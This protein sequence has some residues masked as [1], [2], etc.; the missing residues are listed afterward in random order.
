MKLNPALPLLF[1]VLTAP[2]CA[3]GQ[4]KGTDPKIDTLKAEHLSGLKFRSIGPAFMSGRI[5]DVAV[6]PHK[7]NTWYVGVGS[8]GV[9]KTEN[10]G[11][12]WAMPF[13]N[14]GAAA[15]VVAAGDELAAGWARAVRAEK[16]AAMAAGAP[17]L[18]RTKR[19]LITRWLK[20]RRRRP[21]GEAG[22][23]ARH[24]SM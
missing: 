3:Q 4:K 6:H 16:T 12:T 10:A 21:S 17:R 18:A 8:G 2:F 23:K 1:L 14:T 5:A 22:G 19:R 13:A 11:T 9:W 24:C 7:P 15:V 20:W